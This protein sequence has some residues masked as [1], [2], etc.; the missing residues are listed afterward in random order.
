MFEWDLGAII[1]PGRAK[2]G[3]ADSEGPRFAL[4]MLNQPVKNMAVL[5]ELWKGSCLRVA[6]DGGANRLYELSQSTEPNTFDSLDVIIGDLDSLTPEARTHFESRGASVIHDPDQEST[7]F[8]K[9]IAHIRAASGPGP[10]DIAAVGGL[11]GRVD[12][13][14]SQLHHLYLFQPGAA[15]ERGRIYLVSE[16]SVT[17]QLKPGRHSIRVR[18]RGAGPEEDVFGKYVGIVPV[19]EP[20][21]ISTRGLEWDVEDWATAFGGRMSTSNH[22]LPETECVEV[23]TSR[24]VLFTISLK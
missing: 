9:A 3:E 4:I 23:E 7:D 18:R 14:L 16:E 20:S 5:H 6:A 19:G 13:G 2:A 21:V 1:R 10:I 17:V 8:G 15:Y 12:Q 22:V 11:G 24:D